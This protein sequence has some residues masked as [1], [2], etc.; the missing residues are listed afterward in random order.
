MSQELQITAEQTVGAALEHQARRF[1]D[2]VA[3][4]FGGKRATFGEW[5]DRA[6][7]L[8]VQFEQLGLGKGD[9]V[10]VM[11]PSV[12]ELPYVMLGLAKM[13]AIGV[14]V[15]PMLPPAEVEFQLRDTDAKA[16]VMVSPFANRDLLAMI[17]SL[18]P[19]LPRLGPVIVMGPK[20]EGHASF[21]E[22]LEAEGPGPQETFVRDGVTY[23]DP[24][25]LLFSGGTTGT[26]KAV[27]VTSYNF[28]YVD[29]RSVSQYAPD[30]VMMQIPPLFLTFGFRALA[31]PLLYGLRL[32][33]L[34]AFDPRVILQIIQDEGVTQTDTYPTMIRWVM[35]LPTFDQ[36]DV[37]SMR[38]IGLGGE[39]ITAQLVEQIRQRFKCRMT[40]GYGMTEMRGITSTRL[41]D[42]PELC[43][44]TDGKAIGD[45]E[46]KLVDEQG[47]EVPFGEVGEIV[48]RGRAVFTGYWKRPELNAQV[49]DQDGFFHTGDMA[50]YV[51]HEGYIRFVGRQKDTIRR[52]MMNVYPE[53]V[54]NHLKTNPKIAGVGVIGIP[55]PIT[56]ERIR[57]YV[58]LRPNV[59]MTATEV[60]EYCRGALAGYKVPDEVRF[61]ESLPV[62]ATQRVRR[63][64]LREEAMKE[65][66]QGAG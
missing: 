11:L 34:S 29:A 33:G 51:N 50:R 9:C 20:V 60:V 16:L 31:L 22:M 26:S 54:E 35:S 43:S 25:A 17:E 47:R 24:F 32:V 10:G 55:S 39:P 37:S 4:V 64:M 19:Q 41:D 45:L 62:S 56:G 5:N 36:Y 21:Q 2:K 42:P 40:V 65:L 59:E 63:W 61:V 23:D 48:V 3:L 14:L 8:L 18:R 27:P 15:N 57:A 46:V 58:Q 12:V 44:T 6:N 13:G 66:D 49:F 28:L 1:P 38:R 30:D 52:S 53:E 7:R